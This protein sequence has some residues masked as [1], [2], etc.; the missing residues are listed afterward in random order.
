MLA[1]DPYIQIIE[2][3]RPHTIKQLSLRIIN[4]SIDATYQ[5]LQSIREGS[6]GAN[7][8][9]ILHQ[10]WSL[11]QVL[12]AQFLPQYRPTYATGQSDSTFRLLEYFE[13]LI[14][15]ETISALIARHPTHSLVWLHDGFLVAPPPREKTLRQ[16]EAAVLDRHQLYFNQEWF[17]ITPLAAPYETYRSGLQGAASA[18]VLALTRRNPPRRAGQ[19]TTAQGR[20]HMYMS[21]LEAL[22]KLRARREGPTGRT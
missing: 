10:L 5:Y 19:T 9:A 22:G 14:V 18:P 1:Q 20:A 8:R 7:T 3:V 17:K 12:T 11:S 21:P 4:S 13:A 16:I 6:P 15:E 2:A